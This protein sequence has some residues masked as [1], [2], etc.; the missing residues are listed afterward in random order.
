MDRKN[1]VIHIK[2]II[3]TNGKRETK[4]KKSKEKNQSQKKNYKN[5]R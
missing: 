4:T 3:I 1:I 2:G 5:G